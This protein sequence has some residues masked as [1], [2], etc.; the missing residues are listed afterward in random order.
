MNPVNCLR[1][2]FITP[3]EEE[4]ELLQ[5]PVKN[6]YTVEIKPPRNHDTPETLN[7]FVRGILE[8]QS[9]WFGL[10]NTS[11]VTA[12]EIRR[13][14]PETLRFQYSAPTKRLERKI[15]TQLADQIPR[16]GFTEGVDGIPANSEE[17]LGGGLLTTGRRDWFTFETG[18]D[19]P[20][21]NALVSTLHRHAMQD[22]RFIIQILFQPINGQPIR[23][24]WWRKRAYQ[25][26]NYLTKQKEKLWGSIQP[27]RRE[28]SQAH[29]VDQKT[30]NSRYYTTIRFL[31]IG[32]EEHTPSRIKELTSSF[33]RFENPETGQYLD[34]V[35]IQTFRR[36][37]ILD[38][39]EAVAN[40]RFAGWSRKFRTTT[41][42]LAG[43]VSL[44]SR[45]QNNINYSQP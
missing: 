19:Q 22:T 37:P 34:A 20:P 23:N 31:L 3:S 4:A 7:G 44:P 10:Q 32:A 28:K 43:L 29:N 27:T 24:W 6:W 8:L 9:A 11:P 25:H 33:N 18:F 1:K 42:E 5:Q 21:I 16:V 35:T 30:A 15:R 41:E 26:R 36:K 13:P 17:T 40:R 2:D 12:Y 39:A 14:S 38:F 45:R